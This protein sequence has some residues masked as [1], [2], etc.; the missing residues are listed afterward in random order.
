MGLFFTEPTWAAQAAEAPEAEVAPAAAAETPVAAAKAVASPVRGSGGP[1]S[2]H[3]S[4]PR[5]ALAV[6][7]L[8]ILLVVGLIASVYKIQPWDT[9]L[10]SAFQLLVGAVIGAVIGEKIGIQT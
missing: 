10:P 1:S 8:V 6:G 2:L 4:L 3:L 9:V 7:F 5:L